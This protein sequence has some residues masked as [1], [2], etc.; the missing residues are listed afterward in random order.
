VAAA[1]PE[2]PVAAEAES[3]GP[4]A[5]APAEVQVPSDQELDGVQLDAAK[6]RERR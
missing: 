4:V 3:V 6:P 1:V 5:V 2:R